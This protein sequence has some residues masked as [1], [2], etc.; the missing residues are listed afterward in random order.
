MSLN[1]IVFQKQN[2]GMGRVAASEDPIS[3]IIFHSFPGMN[4]ASLSGF[5]SG[6]SGANNCLVAKIRYTEQLADLGITHQDADDDKIESLTEAQVQDRIARNVIYYHVSEFFRMSPTGTLYIMLRE[7]GT[8]VEKEDIA[9]LQNYAEGSIRQIGV[10]TKDSSKIQDYQDVC[11]ELEQNHMPV[12]VIVTYNGL[13]SDNVS[14]KSVC[15]FVP[16]YTPSLQGTAIDTTAKTFE[17]ATG[18]FA[19]GDVLHIVEQVGTDFYNKG[20]L[21]AGTVTPGT[22][23]DTVT[24]TGVDPDLADFLVKVADIAAIKTERRISAATFAVSL[25]DLTSTTLSA[26]GRCNVSTLVSCDLSL[27]LLDNYAYYGCLGTA[28]GAVSKA[29]VHESI[30]WVQKF[31]LGLTSPGFISGDLLREVSLTN[32][33]LIN[34]NRYLFVRTHVGITDNYFNDSHTLDEVTSDYAYIEN[35]RT[36]DK[37]IRGIRTNLLPYLSSPLQVDATTGK[38][39]S[40]TVAFLETTAGKALEDMEKAG[41]LS[42]YSVAIDPDQNVLATSKLE[43]VIRNVAVGVMRKVHIKIGYTTKL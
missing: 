40:H 17:I 29:A 19:Q 2:G 5:T 12:S 30:A 38:L 25:S 13:Q 27:V 22:P 11:T 34:D 36:I 20:T 24:Y 1:D 3:G 39:S 42:G 37:A 41:E 6:T 14:Y 21:T 32:L 31:P 10:F 33:N 16:N 9:F 18:I 43:F 26:A 23:N 4:Y 7:T 28:L 35:E 15:S 8:D